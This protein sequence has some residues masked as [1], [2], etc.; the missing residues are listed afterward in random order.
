MGHRYFDIGGLLANKKVIPLDE[1]A[2]IL[3][4]SSWT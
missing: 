2:R 1:L 4:E 3:A